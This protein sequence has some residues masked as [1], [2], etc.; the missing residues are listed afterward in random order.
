MQSSACSNRT[1]GP[2]S[3]EGSASGQTRPSEAAEDGAD[4]S[5][6]R[7]TLGDTLERMG[8]EVGCPVLDACT[9]NAG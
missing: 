9:S 3:H 1:G 8:R 2:A 4:L 5:P 6:T 7:H